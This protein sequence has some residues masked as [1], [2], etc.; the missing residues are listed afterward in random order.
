MGSG[1]STVGRLLARQ[2][3]WHHVDLDQR[4][5]ESTGRTISEMFAREGEPTFREIEHREL[6]RVLGEATALSRPIIISLGGGTTTQPQNL[7]LLEQHAATLLWLECPVDELLHRCA[8]MTDRPLF[9]DE[10]SFRNL[11][12]RRLP[13]YELAHFKVDSSGEPSRVMEQILNLGIL[14]KIVA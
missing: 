8:Q 5:T 10:S 13:C 6:T 11:Y 9:R 2:I 14:E 1:K 3:G 7:A 12:Q 4:I